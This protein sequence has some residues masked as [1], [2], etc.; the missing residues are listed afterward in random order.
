MRIIQTTHGRKKTDAH[1]EHSARNE[2]D[3]V[4]GDESQRRG[5]LHSHTA[6]K[7]GFNFTIDLT[8]RLETKFSRILPF[9]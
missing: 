4:L 5:F 2:L 8:I 6:E 9:S 7:N 3:S 1:T